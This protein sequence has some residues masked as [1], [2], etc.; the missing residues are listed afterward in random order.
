[1]PS[2]LDARSDAR[3]LLCGRRMNG[4]SREGPR[5]DSPTLV[6]IGAGEFGLDPERPRRRT[7]RLLPLEIA[8]AADCECLCMCKKEE[9]VGEL[10]GTRPGSVE[11]DDGLCGPGWC[12][13]VEFAVCSL[14]VEFRERCIVDDDGL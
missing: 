14:R 7:L 3:R 11:V 4:K 9:E 12:K 1:M 6:S 5:E 8:A 13:V 2:L 10:E